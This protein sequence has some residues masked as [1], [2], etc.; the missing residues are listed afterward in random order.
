M[1]KNRFF[2]LRTVAL[3]CLLAIITGVFCSI[4]SAAEYEFDTPV[5]K[6]MWEEPYFDDPSTYA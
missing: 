4:V 6:D 1:T 5:D 3:V 2:I